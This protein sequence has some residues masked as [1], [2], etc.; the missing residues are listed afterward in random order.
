MSKIVTDVKEWVVSHP[1]T[2][3]CV[4][5]GVVLVYTLVL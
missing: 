2:S 4:V 1:M 5:V 3:V